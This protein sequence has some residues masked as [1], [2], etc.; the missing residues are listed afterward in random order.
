MQRIEKLID[1]KLPFAVMYYKKTP[2]GKPQNHYEL[3]VI[4]PED[5]E[6]NVLPLD[7]MDIKVLKSRKYHNVFKIKNK[8]SDG[9]VYEFME[10]KKVYDDAV[11]EFNRLMD[12]HNKSQQPTK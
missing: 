12:E 6:L 5:G 7:P 2:A 4:N 1:A 9:R 3:I 8:T 10:F 11:K